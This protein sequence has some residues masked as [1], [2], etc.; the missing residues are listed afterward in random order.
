MANTLWALAGSTIVT[1]GCSM[2]YKRGRFSI[3]HIQNATLSGAI[4]IAPCCDMFSF[5]FP[6]LLIGCF[7]GVVSISAFEFLP[8]L[9][10]KIKY[11]DTRGILYLH[12]IPAFFGAIA[13]SIACGT[14]SQSFYG[15]GP[16]VEYY[17][18]FGRTAPSQGGFQFLGWFVSFLIGALSGSGAGF[19]L[20]I[21]R[22]YRLPID[23]FG[24]HIWWKMINDSQLPPVIPIT[25]PIQNPISSINLPIPRSPKVIA[26][27]NSQPVIQSPVVII[28][29]RGSTI[30]SIPLS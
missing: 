10:T 29:A 7:A 18:L 14:L 26:S 3:D 30:S 9:A 27:I 16:Q 6:A 13:S 8:N 23:T 2:L 12:F 28:P 11:F 17:L 22:V 20:R 21:W 19:V 24:D 4:M 5:P 25:N 1:F 15:S